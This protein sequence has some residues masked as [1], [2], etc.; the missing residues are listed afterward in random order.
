MY[1]FERG[2]FAAIPM[3]NCWILDNVSA[4]ETQGPT[5]ALLSTAKHQPRRSTLAL[6]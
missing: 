1:V 4:Y 3:L 2:S 6:G 5:E